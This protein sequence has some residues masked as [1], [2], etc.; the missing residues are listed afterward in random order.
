MFACYYHKFFPWVFENSFCQ[1]L[2]SKSF[3]KH[4]IRVRSFG[5]STGPDPGA[6]P[7]PLLQNRQCQSE[8]RGR[9]KA[10]ERGGLAVVLNLCKLKL[11][12]SFSLNLVE[13]RLHT[14]EVW[15]V[16]SS[17]NPRQT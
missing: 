9:A 10:G 17:L 4:C 7:E 11:K 5:C 14:V 8:Q 13:V 12:G 16:S 6:D 2:V 3:P 15:G 1:T